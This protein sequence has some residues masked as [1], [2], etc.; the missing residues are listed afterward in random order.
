MEPEA[1]ELAARPFAVGRTAEVYAWGDE[2]VLKLY[3][4]EM[5]H[6]MAEREERIGRIV[7]DAQVGAP[8]VAGL[9]MINGRRGVIY[10]RV[11]GISMLE[12]IKRRPWTFIQ[13]AHVFGR[14]HASMHAVQRA[15]LPSLQESLCEAIAHAPD[16]PENL[17]AASLARLE[18]L[19]NGVAVCHGDYHPDNLILAAGGPVIID[20]MTAGCG[21]PDADVARTVLLLRLGEPLGLSPLQRKLIQL[22]RKQLLHRYLWSYRASRSISAETISAW[23]PVVAAARLHERILS[24]RNQVLAIIETA[25][26]SS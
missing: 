11:K 24:E 19:P 1:K 21:N 17:R 22:L 25:L 23:M 14:M 3:R 16:L 15:E 12:Q 10:G 4:P 20:W 5:P 18:K 13:L 7:M 9:V 6:G 2:Q 8:P 26:G